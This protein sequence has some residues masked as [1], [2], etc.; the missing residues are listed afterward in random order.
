MGEKE[1]GFV[2]W[3]SELSNKDIEIAGGKGA[4]LAELYRHKFPIPPGFVVTANAYKHFIESEGLKNLIHD[5]L[6]GLNTENTEDLNAASKKIREAIEKTPL[7]KDLEEEI[8]EAYDVLDV[9]KHKMSEASSG[10]LEILRTGHEPPF[11]AVRSSSTA[12]DLAEAS[13]AGQQESFL[14]IK[15]EKFLLDKIRKCFSSLF[16]PRAIYYRAKK[17][18]KHEDTY[19]AVVVQK[20]IDAEKSGV[21]FSRNPIK[22]DETILLEAVWGLGEGIVSG[23]IKPDTYR[24]TRDLEK[25]D[26][27]D[28]KIAEKKIA[29]V[30][31]SGGNT[32]PVKLSPEKSK[33]QVLTTYEI[34]RLSQIALESEEHYATPQD[35][36]FAIADKEIYIVQSRPITTQVIENDNKEIEGSSILEGLGASPGISAGTVRII[37]DLNH[38][39]KVRKGDIIVT[40]MTNP[41]MVV[42]MQRAAGIVTDE[43]GVTSHAAIVSREMGIPAVVGTG[44]ATE[45]LKDGQLVTVD[46]N[47]GRVYEGRGETKSVKINPIVPTKTKIKVNV[48]VVKMIGNVEEMGLLNVLNVKVV[49]I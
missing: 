40:Q 7:P 23:R 44:N 8:I 21:V 24:A 30:R 9:E 36:E 38:L 17:K 18:F 1:E 37:E 19:L 45:K 26:I 11:V 47:N 43:G 34:K 35:I 49:G 42:T 4:S 14:N 41:D 12:E 39:E 2:K 10:A 28:A 6:S 16:T 33:Y 31:D 46:G 5:T 20:M 48:V 22:K 27:L 32:V 15:G 29:I 13:F 3:F 25:F